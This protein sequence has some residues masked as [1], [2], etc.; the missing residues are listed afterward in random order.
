MDEKL[1][2]SYYMAGGNGGVVNE[3]YAACHKK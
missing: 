2:R 3:D 1:I